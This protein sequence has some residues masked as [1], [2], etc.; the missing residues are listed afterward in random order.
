MPRTPYS[1]KA[2][3]PV[4]SLDW[5]MPSKSCESSQSMTNELL[6]SNLPLIRMAVDSWLTYNWKQHTNYKE[7]SRFQSELEKQEITG[8]ST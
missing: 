1:R 2:H 5:S 7:M 3:S 8:D 6:L 4:L